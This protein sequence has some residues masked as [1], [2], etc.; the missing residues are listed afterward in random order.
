M[1]LSDINI[2]DSIYIKKNHI[3][4]RDLYFKHKDKP[5]IVIGKYNGGKVQLQ[6]IDRKISAGDLSA[7]PCVEDCKNCLNRKY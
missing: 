4:T 5:M 6:G 7:I 1:R 2:G 3:D